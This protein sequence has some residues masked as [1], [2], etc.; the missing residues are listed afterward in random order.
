MVW[1]HARRH[2]HPCHS[3][4]RQ[5]SPR[6]RRQC[7]CEAFAKRSVWPS[8][9]FQPFASAA[10]FQSSAIDYQVKIAGL[11]CSGQL[12]RQST[13]PRGLN[14]VRSGTRSLISSIRMIE[15]INPSLWRAPIETPFA[16]S[17]RFGWQ[18]SDS[19]AGCP[20]AFQPAIASGVNQIVRLLRLRRRT[21][22]S[23]QFVARWRWRGMRHLPFG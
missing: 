7:Q 9:A 11:V 20:A 16:K 19:D 17:A 3:G 8:R 2:R 5:R 12:N 22:Y 6:C 10:Q 18:G 13:R 15:P 21:S 14:V 23:R 1:I 4:Q